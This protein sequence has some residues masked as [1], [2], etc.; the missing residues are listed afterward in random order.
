MKPSPEAVLRAREVLQSLT[1]VNEH[2]GYP[3]TQVL[4]LAKENVAV[5]LESFAAERVEKAQLVPGVFDCR[6]CGFR[7]ISQTIYV[8]SGNVGANNKPTECSNGCG[9]MWRVSWSD[10]SNDLGKRLEA[11]VLGRRDAVEKARAEEREACAAICWQ[12]FACSCAESIR[13]RGAK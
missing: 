3:F 9:P 6:K 5:A 7:L 10:Y 13:A 11:E 1:A 2:M 12:G 4:M 8:Q